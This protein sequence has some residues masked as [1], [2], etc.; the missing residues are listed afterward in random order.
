MDF[1]DY[2]PDFLIVIFLIILTV[3]FYKAGDLDPENI[4]ERIAKESSANIVYIDEGK[5]FKY[6]SLCTYLLSA[7]V[8]RVTGKTVLAYLQEKIFSDNVT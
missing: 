3:A 6:D 8:Q 5:I 7:I 1:E 4:K 2:I